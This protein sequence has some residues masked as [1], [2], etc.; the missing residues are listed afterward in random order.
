VLILDFALIC[1]KM[2]L[3]SK[4]NYREVNKLTKQRIGVIIRHLRKQKG[5]TQKD[6]CQ[7]S[8]V[9]EITISKIESGFTRKPDTDTLALIAR[10]YGME[11]SELLSYQI[12]GIE[13]DATDKEETAIDENTERAQLIAW[14]V[15]VENEPYI[16]YIY[17]LS[18]T[19]QVDALE[20][21]VFLISPRNNIEGGKE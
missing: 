13:T 21:L 4:I 9:G 6:L 7:K 1:D 20:K 15:K 10:A 18:K 11:L 3:S 16:K 17:D 12:E 5:W 19:I 8:K 2:N 14:A